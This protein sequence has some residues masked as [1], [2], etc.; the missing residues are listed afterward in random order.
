M[1]IGAPKEILVGEKRVALTPQSAAALQKLGYTCIVE[2]NAGDAARF[3]D[4]VYVEAGVT[5]VPTAA[6][7]WSQADVVAKVRA[8]EASE[9]ELARPGQ[10]LIS[11]VY[12]A[13][14]AELL[15]ALKAKGVVTL[16][17]DMVP[18]ISRAQKMDAR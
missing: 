7:L 15:K 11:F 9:I 2:S 18:R 10:I 1:K 17:M 14:N 13:Q 6:D 3:S 16:A 5:V 8:P 12:P 4:A